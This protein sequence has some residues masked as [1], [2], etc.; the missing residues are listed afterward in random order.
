MFGDILKSLGLDSLF[1]PSI[2]SG[3][4]PNPPREGVPDHGDASIPK[5][6]SEIDMKAA[7]PQRAALNNSMMQMLMA[8]MLAQPAAPP[9]APGRGPAPPRPSGQAFAYAPQRGMAVGPRGRL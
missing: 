5:S 9:N 4:S 2:G 8:S 6:A 1:G 3:A 7:D